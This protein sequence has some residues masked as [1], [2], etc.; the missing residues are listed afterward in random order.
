MSER[1]RASEREFSRAGLTTLELDTE[2]SFFLMALAQ[3]LKN[4]S[5]KRLEKPREKVR[6]IA[7]LI[8]TKSGAI[9]IVAKRNWRV[10]GRER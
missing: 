1:K 8:T 5:Q 2:Q 9:D 3:C 6:R 10:K 7:A 4:V